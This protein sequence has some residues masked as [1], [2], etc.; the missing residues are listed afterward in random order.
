[1]DDDKLN[2]SDSSLVIKKNVNKNFYFFIVITTLFIIVAV[3]VF[4]ILYFKNK[5]ELLVETEDL[6]IDNKIGTQNILLEDNKQSEHN[7]QS[8]ILEEVSFEQAASACNKELI[9]TEEQKANCVV[10]LESLLTEAEQCKVDVGSSYF[11]DSCFT[12]LALKNKELS[13][14]N[15]IDNEKRKESCYSGV[16]REKKDLLICEMF[17]QKKDKESCYSKVAL[18]RED[19]SICDKIIGNK[20]REK[21]YDD[22]AY[23]K[24]DVSICKKIEDNYVKRNCFYR[25][26]RVNKNPEYCRIS[27]NDELNNECIRQIEK[28]IRDNYNDVNVCN[29]LED[30]NEK[31]ICLVKVAI[32]T[33]NFSICGLLEKFSLSWAECNIKTNPNQ[34]DVSFC[35]QFELFSDPL[36]R[37]KNPCYKFLAEAKGDPNIC[38]KIEVQEDQYIKDCYELATKVSHDYKFCEDIRRAADHCSKKLESGYPITEKCKENIENA[39]SDCMINSLFIDDGV[40]LFS[41]NKEVIAPYYYADSYLALVEFNRELKKIMD[42]ITSSTSTLAS[43]AQLKIS[44]IYKNSSKSD[45]YALIVENLGPSIIAPINSKEVII[46]K[47]NFNDDNLSKVNWSPREEQ[48]SELIYGEKYVLYLDASVKW[49]DEEENK[50][51]KL[52][53]NGNYEDYYLCSPSKVSLFEC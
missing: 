29:T 47:L 50:I 18:A 28:T 49:P 43:Y 25:Y 38:S 42:D 37:I 7:R 34:V 33:K 15:Y 46:N 10:D 23:K 44:H 22:M 35:D 40:T 30:D 13:F 48:I 52:N 36:K 9:K 39:I 5:S 11:F 14:C 45:S 51:F 26:A 8:M 6:F 16:A 20:Q 41:R 27:E 17:S 24:N 21:C 1:M 4:S 12:I 31:K 19:L 53:I 32:N 2:N 3:I